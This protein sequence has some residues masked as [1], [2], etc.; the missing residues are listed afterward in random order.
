MEDSHIIKLIVCQDIY[1]AYFEK[2]PRILKAKLS[3]SAGWDRL[4]LV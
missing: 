3:L 2:K 1:S 4:L